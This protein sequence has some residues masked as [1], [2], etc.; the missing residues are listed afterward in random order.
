MRVGLTGGPGDHGDP[1]GR[2]NLF[3]QEEVFPSPGPLFFSR[4]TLSFGG[5]DCFLG[6]RVKGALGSTSAGFDSELFPSPLLLPGVRSGESRIQG[7]AAVVS[8]PARPRAVLWLHSTTF[9]GFRIPWGSKTC[10]MPR[11]RLSCLS[12]RLSRR[13][14]FFAWP[15]P[16]SPLTSPRS[17]RAAP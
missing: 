8:S 17:S 4:R 15:M 3:L 12:P 10:L 7:A 5:C 1:G 11:I 16:C 6:G 9:P 14:A 2:K 13:K